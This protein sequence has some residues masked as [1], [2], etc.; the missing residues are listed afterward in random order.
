MAHDAPM[1]TDEFMDSIRKPEDLHPD[2]E[3]YLHEHDGLGYVL[4]H[5]LVYSIPHAEAINAYVNRMYEQKLRMIALAEAEG[6]VAHVVHLHEQP[7]RLDALLEHEHKIRDNAAYWQLVRDIWL[8]TEIFH[9]NY[10]KWGR[11]WLKGRPERHEVMEPEER[12]ALAALPDLVQIYR[13]GHHPKSLHRGFSWTTDRDEAVWFARRYQERRVRPPH[14][15]K[16]MVR[17]EDIL[18]MFDTS[19]REVVV[20]PTTLI[21]VTMRHV[22][23]APLRKSRHAAD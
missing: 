1:T 12:E 3:P 7:W 13:G 10:H 4:Q 19:E 8:A 9:H 17:R 15:C 14:V 18:A 5:P 21:D 22:G 16:A 2:L 6:N 23:Y 20:N 11:L